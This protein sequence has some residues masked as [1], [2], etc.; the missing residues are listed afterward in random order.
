MAIRSVDREER[1]FDILAAIDAI[2]ATAAIPTFLQKVVA[3]YHLKT[4]AFLGIGFGGRRNADP[5]VAVT[6]S[7]DWVSRY[8]T[9]QYQ[10]IDPAVQIG[11]RGLLPMDWSEF[12][13]RNRDVRTL[14]GEASEFGLGKNGLTV[15]VHGRAGERALFSVTSD[16]SRSDWQQLRQFYMRDFQVLAAHLDSLVTRLEAHVLP[17]VA[18]SK[19]ERECLEW[20]TEG[21]TAWAISV[22]LGLSESTVRSYLESARYKLGASSN[23]QAA[24]KALSAGLLGRR[25]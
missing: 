5:L 22:I 21:K 25:L 9:R 18:L 15:P 6:Y 20:I 3:T 13:M 10:H 8:R 11:M 19:R 1:L 24:T 14:F 23:A 16:I 7:F 17:Q 4:A 2:D 12:K